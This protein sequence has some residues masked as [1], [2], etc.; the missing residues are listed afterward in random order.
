MR[1]FGLAV[2]SKER[3][4]DFKFIFN[5]LQKGRELVG[6]PK[7][8]YDLPLMADAADAITNGF[9]EA[10][11]KSGVRGMCWF[12]V[13]K[14]CKKHLSMIKE[15][16]VAAELKFDI[17]KLQASKCYDEF[18]SGSVLFVEKWTNRRRG[19]GVIGAD[20]PPKVSE[21]VDTFLEYFEAQ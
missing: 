12:H 16:N 15:K 19:P 20:L 17:N 7:L 6:L 10:G 1:K 2:V 21:D 3:H 9:R 4:F 18:K 8:S 5:A 13:V 14:N 11:F